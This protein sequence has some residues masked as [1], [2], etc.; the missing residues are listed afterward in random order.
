MSALYTM[1]LAGGKSSRFKTK[2]SK[3]LY[4]ICGRP[5]LHYLLDATQK[6][7]PKETILVVSPT[8]QS[9]F[10]EACADYHCRFAVQSKPAGSGDAVRVGLSKLPKS[11]K[12]LILS[13]DV[14][15][16]STNTMMQLCEKVHDSAAVGS[17]LS[18]KLSCGGAYGRVIS[19]AGEYAL[20]IVEAKDCTEDE[21]E[22]NEVNAGI[23]C[24]DVA[25]LRSAIA[26]LGCHNAQNEYY[27][28]DIVAMANDQGHRF[29]VV[30][31]AC[32][33]ELQGMNTRVEAAKINRT[34]RLQIAIR[35]M[36]AGVDIVDP[37]NVY[38]D[39]MVKI[40]P[41]SHIGPGV[42]LMGDTRIGANVFIHAYSVIQDSVVGDGSVIGPFGR[43]RP[44]AQ[45]AENV[46]IGNFVEIKKSKL[47]KG[48]KVNHLT[49]IGDA[50]VGAD[51]NIGC[52]TITCNYD[53]KEKHRT[54]IGKNV[55]VGSDVAFVAPVTIKDGA[56]IAAGSVVTQNVPSNSLAIARGR[57]VNIKN[58]KKRKK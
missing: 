35:H 36:G 38:I 5:A 23:Y 52:G 54:K 41:D 2:S 58:W 56:T 34:K 25:W 46:R 20:R 11:G 50:D 26:K 12:V 33:D 15:L 55:F 14:P 3:V 8:H 43:L 18:M 48:S 37:E 17:V 6:L 31:A 57:Q 51:S 10:K 29:A 27:L 49:Y 19:S 32:A 42:C 47:G 16:L 45:L 22:I 9:I 7:R 21:L 53:G 39:D 44:G 30:Q 13:G 40:S 4:P 24:V 28:P 1:I